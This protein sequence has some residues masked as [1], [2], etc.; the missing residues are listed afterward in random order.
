MCIMCVYVY[1]VFS[2]MCGCVS[3]CK[4]ESFTHSVFTLH[5]GE[6]ISPWSYLKL[7]I[8]YSYRIITIVT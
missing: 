2:C 3:V 6:K 4:C 7:I 1:Y 5:D 8:F